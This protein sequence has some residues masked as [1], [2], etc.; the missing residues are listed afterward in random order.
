MPALA[1]FLHA[2]GLVAR[3]NAADVVVPVLAAAEQIIATPLKVVCSWPVSGQY[4]PGSRVVYYV[5]VAA[6]VLVR[7][8]EWLRN[9]CLVAAL[10]FPAVAAVHGV[11]LAAV[12][13]PNAVDM[14]I[15][16]VFQFCSIGILTAP[17]TVPLSTTYF[18][19]RGRNTMFI[20]TGIILVGL[21]ALV[22]EFYR[23]EA[24]L[25]DID[26]SLFTYGNSLCG[27]TC[28]VD[29]GPKSPCDGGLQMTSM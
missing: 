15:Y 5:L 23:S 17:I 26:E 8:T 27:L 29:N 7:K 6:C 18:K 28:Y 25:C 14:D 19:D 16:G 20:W 9:A 24:V 22:V 4:G 21:L 2:S 10:V 12:H 13:V 1:P 11:A 3:N